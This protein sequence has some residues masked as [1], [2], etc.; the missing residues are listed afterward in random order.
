MKDFEKNIVHRVGE[1]KDMR[2]AMRS[3][4]VS[5][6]SSIFPRGTI[7]AIFILAALFTVPW[8]LRKV[9]DFNIHQHDA[10]ASVPAVQ[11]H[12]RTRRA[13][14]GAVAIP[15]EREASAGADAGAGQVSIFYSPATNLE[16]LDVALIGSARETIDAA[17]YSATD[18]AVCEAL[19]AAAERHVVV[20]VYRDREQYED[21]E[22]RAHGRPTCTADLLAAGVH[23]RVKGS[24]E[25]M[26]LKAY[27]VD[28][29]TLRTG[30][31]NISRSG[32]QIQDN[33][34][35]V[36]GT[37]AAQAFEADFNEIWNRS[38]NHVLQ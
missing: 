38:D 1:L 16:R 7:V 4:P 34:A 18:S 6:E 10:A 26:H 32:E 19:V 8:V 3:Y 23:V 22:S 31:A 9:M 35:V 33:D 25:Y 21:E 15:S 30:S 2:R 28:Q 37:A 12:K 24:S 17:L 13:A 27:A 29:S 11:P 14:D 5:P 36:L 20:R